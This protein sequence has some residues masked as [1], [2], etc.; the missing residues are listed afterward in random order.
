MKTE[1]KQY[2]E[3]DSSGAMSV[4][5]FERFM[6]YTEEEDRKILFDHIMVGLLKESLVKHCLTCHVNEVWRIVSENT[7]FPWFCV[8][9]TVAGI[10]L[11]LWAYGK[12][13][14][15]YQDFTDPAGKF[16]LVPGIQFDFENCMK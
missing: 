8:G 1:N 7:T 6:D 14:L 2:H 16:E 3:E 4:S 13:N 12:P 10:E 15:S 5:A 11:F 9:S